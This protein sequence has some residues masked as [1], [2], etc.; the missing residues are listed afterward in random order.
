MCYVYLKKTQN[1]FFYDVNARDTYAMTIYIGYVFKDVR[2][3][4]IL[5]LTKL[6]RKSESIKCTGDIICCNVD[7]FLL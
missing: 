4:T 7:S 5:H 2:E 3:N 1:N 6:I